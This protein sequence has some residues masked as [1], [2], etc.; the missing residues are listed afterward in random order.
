MHLTQYETEMLNGKYGEGVAEAM[1]ILVALG[2]AF[3]AERMVETRR[4]HLAFQCFDSDIWFAELLFN[5]GARCHDSVTATCHPLY[6]SDYLAS[7]GQQNEQDD[8]ILRKAQALYKALGMI[9]TRD[10]IPYLEAN[11]PACG[12]VVA[13]S[14]SSGPVYINSVH[15][16]RGN[17]EASNSALAAAITGRVPEYGLL[18]DENRKGNTLVKV[19][20]TLR[21]DFD[22]HLLGYII[23]RKVVPGIPVLT[24]F[25]SKP[26][27]EELASMGAELNVSGTIAMYHIA[28][29]TPEAPDLETAFGGKSPE[30]EVTVSGADLRELHKLL[31]RQEGKIDFV[32]FGC[33]HYTFRQVQ[34]V[35][36]LLE[37]KKIHKNVELWIL[38]SSLTKELSR[39]AGYL[40][41]INKAGGHII[42]DT[43]S[44][45]SCWEH[46]FIGK[47]GMTDSPKAA[48][49]NE[50]RGIEYLMKR[51]RECIE[52]AVRGGC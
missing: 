22:Y 27:T 51:R 30:A 47:V 50:A 18:L 46:R 36:R 24:G 52:A 21:D 19:E 35:A 33:P 38:T 41:T 31:S 44:D 45:H 2:E 28:G 12:E 4:A 17:R 1:K 3:D 34:D 16:A 29:F 42:A 20:A 8:A 23:P 5:L 11:V 32:M 26:S 40:D 43:C 7:V 39:R 48:Y 13:F 37:G 9:A 49:Y 15:G 10:C 25:S 6:D 14:G